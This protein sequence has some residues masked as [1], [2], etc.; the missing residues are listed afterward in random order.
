MTDHEDTVGAESPPP[1]E[2]AAAPAGPQA[3]ASGPPPR[4][5]RTTRVMA[6]SRGAGWVVSAALLGALVTLTVVKTSDSQ[7]APALTAARMAISA[8]APQR[9]LSP[10]PRVVPAPPTG[11]GQAITVPGGSPNFQ[12]PAPWPAAAR[13]AGGRFVQVTPGG[14][15]VAWITPGGGTGFPAQVS[16]RAVAGP[17]GSGPAT[18]IT[19]GRVPA[20]TSAPSSGWVFLGPGATVPPGVWVEI[21]AS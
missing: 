7:T 13:V 17:P 2:V 21:P 1:G 11:P 14:G 19:P 6:T 18:V 10:L 9:A 20:N 4:R 8:R 16:P 5:F 12:A 3:A 15:R